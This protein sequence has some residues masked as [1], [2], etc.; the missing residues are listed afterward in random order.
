[1]RK[2]LKT[3]KW[4][5]VFPQLQKSKRRHWIQMIK[6]LLLQQM[7]LRKLVGALALE[8]QFVPCPPRCLQLTT[9]VRTLWYWR[10]QLELSTDGQKIE[11]SRRL[12][13]HAYP[14]KDQYIPKSSR[15]AQMHSCSRKYNMMTKRGSI[16]KRKMSESE[17]RTNMVDVVTSAQVAML[18]ELLQGLFSRRLWIRVPFLPLSP[19]CPTPQASSVLWSTA[20][21]SWQTQNVGFTCSSKQVRPGFP[22]PQEDDLSLHGLEGNMIC[23]K[24]VRRN[25]KIMKRLIAVGRRKK[26]GLDTSTSL[27][28]NGPCLK[29]EGE[30]VWSGEMGDR[31][32]FMVIMV[33]RFL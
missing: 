30:G 5:Q 2:L 19:F 26:P 18:A 12:Q 21:H 23:P 8:D 4:N 29:T 10:Q 28:L 13:E 1:M 9:W 25:K 16:Q 6:F 27:L 3:I 7:S 33:T 11:V 14:E 32:N 20:D 24:C 17:E 31:G 22:T 15:E